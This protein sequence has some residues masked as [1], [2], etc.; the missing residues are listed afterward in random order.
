M[1]SEWEVVGEKETE[2]Q[3][4][5]TKESTGETTLQ[6]DTCTSLEC[7]EHGAI[8]NSTRHPNQTKSEAYQQDITMRIV[9]N[10]KVWFLIFLL[11][12]TQP[13]LI[14]LVYTNVSS[15]QTS[16]QVDFT[17]QGVY[18]DS[19]YSL[20]KERWLALEEKSLD[21]FNKCRSSIP[22]LSKLSTAAMKFYGGVS[23]MEPSAV[24]TVMK[25]Y[26][27][28]VKVQF[29]R[30]VDKWRDF[31]NCLT[32]DDWLHRIFGKGVITK[33]LLSLRLVSRESVFDKFGRCVQE[34]F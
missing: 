33:F 9:L 30:L 19:F 13:I 23:R 26:C 11:M 4:G 18:L 22:D 21:L 14:S 20:N 2:E 8:N 5:A 25:D 6:E 32:R 24:V 10:G 7:Y 27:H 17:A 15:P 1:E 12:F 28:Q 34:S 29:Q 16:A 3:V 31:H